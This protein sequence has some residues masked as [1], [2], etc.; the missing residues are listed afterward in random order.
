VYSEQFRNG[1]SV[2]L[3]V[4]AVGNK[5]GLWLCKPDGASDGTSEESKGEGASDGISEESV[6]KAEGR[7]VGENVGD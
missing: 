4:A 7:I 5:L 1:S 2:G 3:I 6:G